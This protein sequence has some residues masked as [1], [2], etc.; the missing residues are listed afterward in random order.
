MS[1]LASP[2]SSWPPVSDCAI[3]TLSSSG[4]PPSSNSL[5]ARMPSSRSIPFDAAL[6]TWMNGLKTCVKR[7]SGRAIKRATRSARLIA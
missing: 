7:C 5:V 4:E 2:G 3:S 1:M 6:R